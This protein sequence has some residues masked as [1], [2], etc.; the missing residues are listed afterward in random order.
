MHDIDKSYGVRSPEDSHGSTTVSNQGTMST[1]FF[2]LLFVSFKNFS[3]DSKLS[4][5]FNV[6]NSI[7]NYFYFELQKRH[8]N[9]L[10]DCC[11][12]DSNITITRVNKQML[13]T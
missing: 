11:R 7:F 9:L 10:S 6:S 2:F 8:N 12:I 4:S 1:T 13:D 3:S 5:R